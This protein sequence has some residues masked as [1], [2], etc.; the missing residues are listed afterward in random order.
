MKAISVVPGLITATKFI[1]ISGADVPKATTVS[2]MIRFEMLN[3]LASPLEPST[4][5]L[6]PKINSI[7]PAIMNK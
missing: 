4:S 6:A 3:L 1:T 2:P 5:Q 7:N